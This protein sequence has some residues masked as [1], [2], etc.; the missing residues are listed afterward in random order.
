M[1]YPVELRAQNLP[2][3]PRRPGGPYYIRFEPPS[4]GRGRVREVHRSLRKTVIAAAKERVKL[5]IEP[6]L[7]GQWGVAE[8]LKTRSGYATI[9]DII[10]RYL[11]NAQDRPNTVRNNVSALRLL[12]RTARG[13]EPDTPK[14][15]HPYRRLSSLI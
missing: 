14:F 3:P 5:I 15:G 2:A 1:L 10:E 11:A 12:V 8:K 7:N 4:N 9:G 13:T 6:I